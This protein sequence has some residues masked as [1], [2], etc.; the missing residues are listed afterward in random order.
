MTKADELLKRALTNLNLFNASN[1]EKYN[2]IYN[3][4]KELDKLNEQETFNVKTTGT[5]TERLCEIG[6]KISVPDLYSK[7]DKDFTWIGDFTI[8]ANPFNIIITVKSYKAKERLISSG[9]GHI[10]SPTIGY[11][12]FDDIQ[13]FTLKRIKSYSLRAF[14]A[15]YMPNYTYEKLPKDVTDTMNINGK[16]FIRKIE[17]MPNDLSTT[18][19]NRK[20]D[21]R[22]I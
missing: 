18:I 12:L 9:S 13:E 10:L 16:P 21:I 4:S 6:L 5:I 15:L 11:G 22:H 20:I 17:D 7:M 2:N 1:K 8:Q 3:I 14:V 19:V